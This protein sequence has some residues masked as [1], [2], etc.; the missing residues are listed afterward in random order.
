M[1]YPPFSQFS[2]L[3]FRKIDNPI[4]KHL[5]FWTTMGVS[6]L[7]FPFFIALGTH[8][9]LLDADHATPSIL[10]WGFSGV[11][12]EIATFCSFL[13]GCSSPTATPSFFFSKFV[14]RDLVLIFDE[15]PC[16]A[17]IRA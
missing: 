3:I 15:F 8:H 9:V 17:E 10:S 5:Q 4:P 6:L 11:V 14:T 7:V 2:H 12:G 13:W 16:V 1:A